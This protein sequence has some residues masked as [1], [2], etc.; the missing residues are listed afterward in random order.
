MLVSKTSQKRMIQ[1][2]EMVFL[3]KLI[4]N[5]LSL[6]FILLIKSMYTELHAAVKLPNGVTPHFS[7]LVGVRQGCNLS[8][9]LFNLFVN[10]IF[11]LLTMQSVI[12]LSYKPN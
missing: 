2:G 9:M 11:D 8:P 3:Y 5:G 1:F 12:Q 7:S 10:D 4:L 6:K